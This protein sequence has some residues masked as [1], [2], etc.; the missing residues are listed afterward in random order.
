MTSNRKNG[1]IIF[2][3]AVPTSIVSAAYLN[4]LGASEENIQL[5]LRVTARI[6]F[7]IYFLVFVRQTTATAALDGPDE[8][9]TERELAAASHAGAVCHWNRFRADFAA[10]ECRGMA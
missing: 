3:I 10:F 9:L 5:L 1:L 8:L 2:G 4:A 6:A 7:L